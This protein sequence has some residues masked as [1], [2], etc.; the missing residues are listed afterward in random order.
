M[1][2]FVAFL[3][4]TA[5]TA[6]DGS[7]EPTGPLPAA[8][9][10]VTLSPS[11]LDMLAG[12]SQQIEVVLTDADGNVLTDR[13]ITYA[14]SDG[15]VATVDNSGMVIAL[16]KGSATITAASEGQ[17]GIAAVTVEWAEF[18]PADATTL[19]GNQ[20]FTS[21]TVPDGVKVTISGETNIV[22]EGDVTIAGTI[23]GDCTALSINGATLTITGTVANSC[24]SGGSVDLD[25]VSSGDLTITGV[26][27]ESSGHIN[28]TNDTT[29][30]DSDFDA[31]LAPAVPARASNAGVSVCRIGGLVPV[32]GGVTRAADGEADS[33]EGGDGADGG[34]WRLDCRGDVN[35]DGNADITGGT[36]MNTPDAGNGGAGRDADVTD[37]TKTEVKG[38]KGGNGGQLRIRATGSV[39]FSGT[40][41]NPTRILLADGG[42]GGDAV[43][44]ATTPGGSAT[45]TAGFGGKSGTFSV[46]ANG[47]I[48]IANPGGLEIV[49][50]EGGKGGDATATGADGL[51]AQDGGAASATGGDGGAT[52]DAQLRARGNVTG[53]ANI[54]MSGGNGGK[55]GASN[56]NA[57]AGGNGI[58]TDKNG[59][60]GGA[61]NARS[62]SGGDAQA[63][64]LQGNPVGN[65]GEAG[66]ADIG[67]GEGGDGFDGCSVD[68]PEAGG[69]G[70]QGGDALGVLGVGGSG[71][72]AGT[73]GTLVVAAATGDGGNGGDGDAPG[74]GGKAGAD[75]IVAGLGGT[76]V[77]QGPNFRDGSDGEPCP[78]F[79]V[80]ASGLPADFTHQVGLTPCPQIIGTITITNNSSSESLSWTITAPGPLGTSGST[81]GT[82]QLGAP[83]TITV[84]FD[85]SQASSFTETLQLVVVQAGTTTERSYTISGSVN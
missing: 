12:A 16:T 34:N 26:T 71:V 3:A 47:N 10:T 62:G 21:V 59:G 5:L 11:T 81:T 63:K 76:R 57:G 43:M 33:S 84:I 29:L 82:L 72:V 8:V 41:S 14:S 6:C 73:G 48:N 66:D 17:N 31:L 56:A 65:G 2:R 36:E 39:N 40:S 53:A 4:L 85:C 54:T 70:G 45:A 20:T 80:N 18:A 23:S 30:S 61:M 49:V 60:D 55:G 83:M 58:Q 67:G 68:P 7:V 28:I 78:N 37:P 35:I 19:S 64:D 75:N 38:G 79:T 74:I 44:T 1:R 22:S 77:D 25:L 9:A 24:S 69:N 32:Q 52:P 50:G 42:D 46:Q 15:E 51:P 13:T 27:L